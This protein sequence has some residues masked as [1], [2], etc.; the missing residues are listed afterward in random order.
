MN[1]IFFHITYDF[2]CLAF[3]LRFSHRSMKVS[4]CTITSAKVL[5]TIIMF[6][7]TLLQEAP[8]KENLELVVTMCKDCL[9][10]SKDDLPVKM[11]KLVNDILSSRDQ[12]KQPKKK[13]AANAEEQQSKKRAIPDDSGAAGSKKAKKD[14]EKKVAT[15]K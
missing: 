5:C 6:A 15:K 10:T 1:K 8:I 7:E 13:A 4:L 2:I 9:G 3:M 14:N 12:G 11:R